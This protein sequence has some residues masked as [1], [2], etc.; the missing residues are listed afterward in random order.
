MKYKVDVKECINKMMEI[1]GYNTRH[2][3]ILEIQKVFPHWYRE[4][5]WTEAEEAEFKKWFCKHH[6]KAYYPWFNLMWGLTTHP[7]HSKSAS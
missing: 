4:F 3:H 6:Y 1:A 7:K 2:H 5:W